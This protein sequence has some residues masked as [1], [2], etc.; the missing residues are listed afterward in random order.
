MIRLFRLKA[1]RAAA[2]RAVLAC[3]AV[4]LG[5]CGGVA[6][7]ADAPVRDVVQLNRDWRF[8]LGD[9]A[10]A[11]ATDYRERD[12]QH[13]HLPH[14]FSMPYFLGSGFYVGY[15]WYRKNVHIGPAWKDR[16][17]ALEFDGV[18]QDTEVFVNGQRAGR[19]RGGYTGFTIDVTPYVHAGDNLV[20]IRV[21]NVWNPR[22][23]PRAGEHVFSG[24]IYRD[25][26]LVATNPVHVAWYGTWVTTPDVSPQRATVHLQTEVENHAA[27]EQVVTLK[28]ILVDPAGRPA[29][30]VASAFRIG[31]GATQVVRQEPPA[32]PK[33]ALWEPAHPAMYQLRSELYIG[34]RLVD[35]F[36]TPF[37]IRSIAWTADRGFFLNGKHMYLLGANVHQDQA[38]W[39]DAVTQADAHRDVKLIKDAGFNFI[40]GSHYPHS[41][42]F[43]K[44]TDELGVLFWSEVP[45][46]GIGGSGGDGNWLASAYPPDPADR[47]EFEA[48]V[49][50]QAAEMIRIHRNHPSIVA[51]SAGNEAFFTAPEALDAMRA[52]M[53]REVDFMRRQD[54]SRP[55]AVG[56]AQR[57][58]ID[59]LGDIAGYN[60]DGASLPE[61]QDPGIANMVSE[62]GSTIAERPGRYEPGWGNLVD[63]AAP[64]A[65]SDPHPWR[66]PWRSGEAIWAGFDHGTI[67]AVEFGRMG[68]IDYFRIPKRQYYWYRNAYAGVAPPVWPVAGEPSR[69]A[70][71]ADKRTISGTQGHDDVQL[72]VTVLDR[73]GRALSNSPA[74]T[75][76]IERGPGEFPT[77]RSITFRPDSLIAI[78]DGQ[79]AITF[80][81]YHAGK[82]VIRAT[83]PGLRP[84]T[85]DITTTGPDAW[86]EG[87][88][89]VVAERRVVDY[90]GF[91]KL[92][93]GPR[94][95]L[96]NRPTSATS[97]APG[98]SSSQA[99]DG[100]D[101]TYWQAADA[102]QEAAWSADLEN[103]YS[104]R[105]VDIKPHVALDMSF[106]VE[107]SLDRVHWQAIG[108]VAGEKQRHVLSDFGGPVNARFIRIRFVRLPAQGSASLDEVR[109]LA[110]PAG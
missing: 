54:P 44:A 76:T 88:T 75:L 61:Y 8:F 99:N 26:R 22:L 86:I 46:W 19:H 49:L 48:S 38:G 36:T 23:A 85:V 94:N 53:R 101:T 17:I 25:V 4:V 96:V 104:L 77:G 78:R 106:I 90:P 11:A 67:A 109:V 35:A 39:G 47:P 45:F 79:A 105:S 24:G 95:I 29:G 18:F 91:A 32:V 34:G 107:A 102:G 97:V 89:P 87:R 21:N 81:S 64:R 84:A 83:S 57:G 62:Y 15:G 43:S 60:G 58:A 103:I 31:P 59:H 30:Q 7:A 6:H 27:V 70:L 12:W 100:D 72:L 66:F 68:L 82:T 2:A 16:R 74:V 42:A 14:S 51:W 10:G 1:A 5:L 93:D 73:Q 28:S 37:G 65:G 108:T 71:T 56:G 40:R 41:P 13:I 110:V 20:A 55:I 52:F 50:A 80:R 9:D 63:S 69:L 98:H 92:A 33:P 3:L